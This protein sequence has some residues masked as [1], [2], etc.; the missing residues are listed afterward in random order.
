M[1]DECCAVGDESIGGL[2]GLS[3]GGVLL[4]VKGGRFGCLGGFHG[5]GESGVQLGAFYLAIG[6][7]WAPLVGDR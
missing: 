5:G 3:V 7:R 6:L 1:G 2:S 4:V